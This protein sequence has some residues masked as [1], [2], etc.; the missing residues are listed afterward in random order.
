MLCVLTAMAYIL[1]GDRKHKAVQALAC[2]TIAAAGANLVGL[3]KV[4][5]IT[6]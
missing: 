6:F 5:L 4:I 2:I 3:I 1:T